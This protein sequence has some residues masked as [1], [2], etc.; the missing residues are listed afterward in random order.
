MLTENAE[1]RAA[2][3]I[4]VSQEA[5]LKAIH[6]K[7]EEKPQQI[8]KPRVMT[9]RSTWAIPLGACATLAA[10]VLLFFVFRSNPPQP[11]AKLKEP[12]NGVL[13]VR[14]GKNVVVS[15]DL[16]ILANDQIQCPQSNAATIEYADATRVDLKSDTTVVVAPAGRSS[17][18]K[19]IR[20]EHGKLSAVVSKQP[21][22]NPLA[23]VSAQAEATVLGTQLE[24]E[25]DSRATKLSV[26]EGN[27]SFASLAQSKSL[28]VATGEY[29]I[30]G[31]GVAF[32]G[33]HIPPPRVRDGMQTLYTFAEGGGET[34]KDVSGMLRR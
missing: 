10:G 32:A 3:L 23:F 21:P 31:E 11:V 6:R 9:K 14:D 20:I 12:G 4:A 13:V 28:A 5:A 25:V 15:N 27:V 24:M 26:I 33:S 18:G 17:S 2:F 34:I 1:L 30:A 7:P 19:C 16:E 29:A 8:R 22:G